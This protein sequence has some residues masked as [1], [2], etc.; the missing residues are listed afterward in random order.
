MVIQRIAT[1]STLVLAL[2]GPLAAQTPDWQR[3]VAA[4]HQLAEKMVF[5]WHGHWA[6]SV[7]KVK[8]G[9]LMQRQLAGF[10]HRAAEN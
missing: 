5:F 7:Q 4:E 1:I 8:S 6:T 2:A 10:A 9:P 3:A